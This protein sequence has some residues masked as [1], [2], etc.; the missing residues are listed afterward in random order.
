MSGVLPAFGAT[1][2]SGNYLML[3]SKTSGQVWN[4]T[5]MEIWNQ[6]H[7]GNYVIASP[8]QAGSGCYVGTP[9]AGLPAD[10]YQYVMYTPLGGG[11]ASGD[12]P[13]FD[14][15]FAY[16][17]A[18]IIWIGS[19]MNVGKINGSSSAAVALALSANSIIVGAAAAGTLTT[20]QMTTNLTQP[21]ANIISG[22]VLIFTSG[23]NAGLRVL[24]TGYTVAGGLIAFIG[25]GNA[26]APNVP[27]AGDTFI[28][29]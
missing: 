9:P 5:A 13:I 23:I 15:D 20:S 11:P 14:D 8:E 17:G 19:S 3:R 24:V 21:V 10:T 22:A 12:N 25:Y 28:I 16:D 7:W 2:N 29:L 1:G 4:G 18:N 6:S 26:V 27:A